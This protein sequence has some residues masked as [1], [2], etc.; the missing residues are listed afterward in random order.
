MK[1]KIILKWIGIGSI[2]IFALLIIVAKISSSRS[3]STGTN[4]I[5]QS[6]DTP[7]Q[8]IKNGNQENQSNLPAIQQNT[9]KINQII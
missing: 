9:E 8:E 7:P 4:D 2:L 1:L 5:A 6:T 3:N